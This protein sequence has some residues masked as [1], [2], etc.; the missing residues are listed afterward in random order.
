MM[1]PEEIRGDYELNTGKVIVETF[2]DKSIQPAQMP[3]VLVAGH[4]P[5][6]WG[7]NAAKSVE[8]SVVLEQVALMA[9]KT[10]VIN[11][12]LEAIPQVLL[13]KHYLRKHGKNAYYGQKNN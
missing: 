7:A 13:D 11:P 6:T 12:P 1:S 10:A 3:A 9:I 8:S 5:F 4:G 2:R